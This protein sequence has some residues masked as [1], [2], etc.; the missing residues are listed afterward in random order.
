M[1]AQLDAF[2]PKL[3]VQAR[4]AIPISVVNLRS[5]IASAG[6]ADIERQLKL[7]T[8]QQLSRERQL[9][10]LERQKMQLLSGKRSWPRMTPH[11]GTAV[12]SWKEWWIRTD[13]HGRQWTLMSD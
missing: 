2:F 3:S 9:F 10:I 5:A 13:I 4:D 6:A 8:I 1:S 11:F 12:I 7:L